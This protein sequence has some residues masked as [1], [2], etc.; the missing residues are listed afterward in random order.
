[1][2]GKKVAAGGGSVVVILLLVVL[3]FL[4]VDVIY[5]EGSDG[6]P[7]VVINDG[8]TQDSGGAV[9]DGGGLMGNDEP[10]MTSSDWYQIYFTEPTCPDESER[11]GGIDEIMADDIRQAREQVDIASFDLDLESLIEAL[12]DREENG[13]FVRVVVDDEHTPAAA[14]NRLRRNGISVVVDDRSALMHNKFV[15]IDNR[16]VWTGSTNFSSNGIYCNNNNLVRFEVPQ[17]VSNYVAEMDEMY[18]DRAFGVRSPEATPAER[19]EANGVAFENYF[20][21]E[22]KKVEGII[23]DWVATADEEVLILAFSFTNDLIGAAVMERAEA[24][25]EVWAIFEKTGSE[26]EYSY[27]PELRDGGWE[28]VYA[29]QD[30]NSRIMHHKVMV[31][32]RETVIMGSYNFTASANDSN[33]ENV[34]IITDAGFASPF[35]DEFLR[36]WEEAEIE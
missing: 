16:V 15:V 19:F 11:R 34:V 30:G 17:L 20:S 5:E 21:P 14:I 3:R 33:D 22:G 23:A 31:I 36:L 29:A 26:T 35:V 1:M 10:G 18:D 27:Y 6:E 32:D 24:G 8:A 7:V 9:D 28:K 12:I 25:V 4:G 13:V 2:M